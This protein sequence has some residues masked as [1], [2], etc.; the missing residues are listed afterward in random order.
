MWK[1]SEIWGIGIAL[2]TLV[3]IA[4]F[5][6]RD[7][8]AF[9]AARAEFTHTQDTASLLQD[10]LSS[11]KDLETGQR[12]FVIVGKPSYLAPYND[13]KAT[14]L[15]KLAVL[16][17]LT[18]GDA[19]RQAQVQRIE[20]LIREKMAELQETVDLRQQKGFG[21]ALAVV[22]QGSG[23]ALMDQLRAEIASFQ[24]ESDGRLRRLRGAEERYR[25][26]TSLIM[27]G[28]SVVLFVLLAIAAVLVR[29]R[30]NSRERALARLDASRREVSQVRDLLETTLR[31]IGD[32]V[33]T[34]DA[35]GLITF[36]NPMAQD[37]TGWGEDC[38]GRPLSEVFHIVNEH[39]REPVESPVDKV[40]RTGTVAG[41]ANHTVL[42][43]RDGREIPIDDSGAP[44]RDR[45][46]AIVGFVL[47][48]R[49]IAERKAAEDALRE[50]ED[51]FRTMANSAP[52]LLWVAGPDGNLTFVNRQWVEFTGRPLEENLKSGWTR[53]VH[54]D[55]LPRILETRKAAWEQ[56]KAYSFECRLR[57]ADGEYRHIL[58]TGMP[59]F[60]TA[61]MLAGYGSAWFDITELKEAQRS[62][63]ISER[64]FRTLVKGTT[65]MVWQTDAEGALTADQPGW[66]ELTGQTPDQFRGFGGF[67]VVHPDDRQ[68]VQG[69][70]RQAL[71][72]RQAFTMEFRLWHAPSGQYRY[73]MSRGIPLTAPDGELLQWVGTIT[74]VT[75]RRQLEARL[76]EAAKLESLGVLVGG[77]AHDFNNLLVGVVGNASLL[78]S[79]VTNADQQEIAGQ[80]L[81]AGERAAVLTQQ[82]LAYSGRGR[83][84]V[85]PTDLSSETQEIVELLRHSIPKHV[86]LIVNFA[87]ELPLVEIDRAQ[88]Q[89]VVMNLAINGAEAIDGTS[90][91]VTVSTYTRNLDAEEIALLFSGDPVKPGPYAVLEVRDTGRGM[92]PDTQSRMFD[93]FFTTKFTGRGLGLAAVMGIVRGHH[94]AI[95]VQSVP[96][97]GTIFRVLLPV[98]NA[99]P[100]P[101]VGERKNEWEL[102]KTKVLVVDDEL[103]VRS[104]ARKALVAHG[105]DV[106]LA[107]NGKEAIEI[108]E[109]NAAAIGIVVLDL[110]MPLMSGEEV[111]PRL[112]ALRP[113]LRIVASSGYHRAEA[114]QRFGDAVDAFLQKPY[115]AEKL[116]EAV[117]ASLRRSTGA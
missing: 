89:Q 80:I 20:N 15:S 101:A 93:P 36:L 7:W 1:R 16:D 109:A 66:E 71:D 116:L 102:P 69:K 2:V 68:S 32:A 13:G 94:G 31:S 37:L 110:T 107:A 87:R 3:F 41:L 47:V 12:G 73:V 45:H 4:F 104:V 34:T 46:N 39:T 61:G 42:L 86:E 6:Y 49:D 75:E 77:I 81:A 91:T 98:S 18:E 48:F 111:L 52:V 55:D 51:R 78:Q 28:G 53:S 63:E 100:T 9:H 62:L 92:D 99:Q 106:L 74:D 22:E 27:G 24:T 59:R 108:L 8:A 54:P 60:T 82:M 88:F 57:R 113:D 26:R 19:V 14:I 117:T 44:I 25:L 64:R 29:R 70:W 95:H 85:E 21:A 114:M 76:R 40:R 90:G 96:G 11:A 5:G 58:G 30:S 112:R 23:K 10:V 103:V 79:M 67:A 72:D 83:F 105:F 97:S 65:S 35:E 84:I 56:R 33:I 17:R 115:P 50:S 43:A 38:Y